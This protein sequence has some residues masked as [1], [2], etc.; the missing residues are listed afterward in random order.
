MAAPSDVIYSIDS[1]IRIG[2]R[3]L[4]IAASSGEC[5]LIAL[6][7]PIFVVNEQRIADFAAK[8]RLPSVFHLP[9]FAQAGGLMVYGPDR[10]DLFRRAATYVDKILRGA[11]PSDLP[12]E[13]ATKFQL[14]IN[15]NTAKALGLTVPQAILARA[16]EVIE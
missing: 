15:L 5:G 14:I 8:H 9:E 12:V 3:V 13:Q 4:K 6:P 16:D 11:N 2:E 1:Y 7:S 10:A